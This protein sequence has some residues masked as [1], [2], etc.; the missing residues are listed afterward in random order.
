MWLGRRFA[1]RKSA[2][3]LAGRWFHNSENS[4]RQVAMAKALFPDKSNSVKDI[5]K[6]L[7]ISRSSFSMDI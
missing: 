7:G 6:T 2:E 3:V 5:C 1:G 4:A